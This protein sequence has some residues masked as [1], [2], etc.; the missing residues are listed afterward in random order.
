M[1][2]KIFNSKWFQWLVSVT[3]S[4][5]VTLLLMHNI[6]AD[7]VRI[8]N[9]INERDSLRIKNDRKILSVLQTLVT[10]DS[11][12]NINAK[13]LPTFLPLPPEN[14]TRVSSNYGRRIIN[15]DTTNHIGTDYSAKKGTPI[16]A[17][18]AGKV[19]KKEYYNGYGNCIIIDS[20]NGVIVTYGHQDKMLVGL[21]E[22]VQQGQQ[23]STVGNSGR[24]VGESGGNHLHIE[25]RIYG[26]SY[27]P[28]EFMKI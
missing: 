9:K 17:I 1:L 21:N 13:R 8:D 11:I 28:A 20:G 19:I 15:G 23:I 12:R 24:A 10:N 25:I 2:I 18:A 14:M 16:Y 3:I 26:K 5:I 6:K 27:N 4:V 7:I 22:E